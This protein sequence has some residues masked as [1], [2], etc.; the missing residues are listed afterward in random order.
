MWCYW[1]ALSFI[2]ISLYPEKMMFIFSNNTVC[3]APAEVILFPTGSLCVWHDIAVHD[4]H[5]LLLQGEEV[6]NHQLQVKAKKTKKKNFRAPA[7]RIHQHFSV[8]PL[9]GETR[10]RMGRKDKR[11]TKHPGN[12]LQRKGPTILPLSRRKLN[13]LHFQTSRRACPRWTNGVPPFHATQDNVTLLSLHKEWS[14]GIS[15]YP[16]TI[17]PAV[18]TRRWG[19]CGYK[20]PQVGATSS[21]HQTASLLTCQNQ[22][23][24]WD[25]ISSERK[26]DWKECVMQVGQI[27][28][29]ILFSP[30]WLHWG[31]SVKTMETYA[32]GTIVMWILLPDGQKLIQWL[33]ANKWIFLLN[34][35]GRKIPYLCLLCVIFFLYK[36]YC[37]SDIWG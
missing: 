37:W 33:E 19:V 24:T 10:R 12:Q 20:E 6:W 8:A 29:E 30:L 15:L 4:E 17:K 16:H 26:S 7:R 21:C 9:T 32:K 18:T 31:P 3:K 25:K 23:L 2:N 35:L 14:R 34:Q 11:G 22:C 27:D 5:Q 1:L 28:S 36:L 13:T